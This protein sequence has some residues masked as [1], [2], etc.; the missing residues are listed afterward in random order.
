MATVSY[1]VN[2]A[3]AREERR[4]RARRAQARGRPA[5]A[6]EYQEARAD[7]APGVTTAAL[8]LAA[9]YALERRLASGELRGYTEA[10]DL[11]GGS[12]GWASRILGLVNLKPEIQETILAGEAVA[13][14]RLVRAGS[15]PD[16]EEQRL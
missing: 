11:V 6:A 8:R 10:A 3:A 4:L 14:K 16:W 1:Q 7:D 15:T 12:S 13:G 5:K 9:A 2:F